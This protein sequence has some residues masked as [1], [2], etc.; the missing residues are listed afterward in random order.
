MMQWWAD[1]LDV[2]RAKATG[3]NVVALRKG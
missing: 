2:E 3:E 1:F